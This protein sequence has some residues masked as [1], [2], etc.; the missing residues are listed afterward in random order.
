VFHHTAVVGCAGSFAANPWSKLRVVTESAAFTKLR[1]DQTAYGR[2]TT[3]A[4]AAGS[5]AS[6]PFDATDVT[7]LRRDFG[8]RFVILDRSKLTHVCARVEQALS[9]LQARRSLGGDARFEV[10]DLAASAGQ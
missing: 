7:A 2:I 9:V 4:P 8:V 10:I 6:A 3:T 5:P 1:C